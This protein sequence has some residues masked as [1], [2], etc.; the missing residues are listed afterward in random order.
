MANTINKKL[1]IISLST[2]QLIQANNKHNLQIRTFR[3]NKSN[4][5]PMNNQKNNYDLLYNT[6]ITI[7]NVLSFYP[8]L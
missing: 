4:N 6:I 8:N 7:K 2:R 3:F 5:L 1:E